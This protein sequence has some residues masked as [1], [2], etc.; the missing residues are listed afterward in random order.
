M[1]VA[2]IIFET[3][4]T[5]KQRFWL[6]FPKYFNCVVLFLLPTTIF[7]VQFVSLVLKIDAMEK[8]IHQKQISNKNRNLFLGL[9]FDAIG[10][11]SFSIP[12]L[13]EFTDVIWAPLAG[14]LM[15][16][17]YKG[18]VG[19][20]GGVL[21]FLEEIIPFTDFIPSFTLTWIYNYWIK[22]EV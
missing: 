13:G 7:P 5:K 9:V 17:M 20:V 10:M 15:T 18:I 12:Y 19:K 3:V 16:W 4:F 14:Y 8:T 1:F 2:C 6:P 11:L 21:T 22:K